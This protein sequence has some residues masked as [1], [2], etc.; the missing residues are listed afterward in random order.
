MAIFPHVLARA[1]CA[2]WPRDRLGIR[3]RAASFAAISAKHSS[4]AALASSFF[5]G[6]ILALAWI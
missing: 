2:S 3:Q 6:A 4:K 5:R 1:R